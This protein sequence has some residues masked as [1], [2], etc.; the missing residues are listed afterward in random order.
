MPTLHNDASLGIVTSRDASSLRPGEMVSA[1]GCEYHVGSPHLYKLPGRTS[2]DTALGAAVDAVVKLQYESG[3]IL[4]AVCGGSVYESTL[5][6]SPTFGAATLTG[7]T[8]G[9]TPQFTGIQEKWLMWNG[10][11]DNYLR[12]SD[13]TWR[14]VGMQPPLAAP[15]AAVI[16]GS[17][18]SHYPTAVSGSYGNPS[19]A[20]DAVGDTSSIGMV[21][22]TTSTRTQTWKF[23][24]N[25]ATTNRYLKIFHKA[26][27]S[28]GATHGPAKGE[29]TTTDSSNAIVTI[30]YSTD[31][32]VNYT[33]L[34][35]QGVS[36][37]LTTISVLLNDALVMTNN[38]YVKASI[39]GTVGFASHFMYTIKVSAGRSATTPVTNDLYYGFTEVYID[40]DGIVHEGNM[41]ESTI[42]KVDAATANNT[43][44]ITLTFPAKATPHATKYYIYRSIMEAGGGY[45]NMYLIDQVAAGAGNWIDDFDPL[46]PLDEAASDTIY[47]TLDVLYPTGETLSWSAHGPPP[48]AKA[49]VYFNGSALYLPADPSLGSRVYYSLPSTIASAGLEQIPDPYY[50]QFQTPRNDLGTALAVT[51]GG[52]SALVFFENYTMIVNY[53]PQSTDPGGFDNRVVEYVS[54]I[55][56]CAG[57]RATMEFTLPAGQTLVAAVDSLGLWVTNGVNMVQEWSKDLDWVTAFNG[58]DLTTVTLVDK[59]HK[60]RLELLFVGTDGTHQEYHFFY[61]RMKQ[62]GDGGPAPLITGPHP[63]GCSCKHYCTID[64]VWQGFGGDAST[65]GDVFLEDS[66]WADASNGYDTEGNI[67]WVWESPDVYLQGFSVAQILEQINPKFTDHGEPKA[68]TILLSFHRDKGKSYSKTKTYTAG[69]QQQVYVHAYADRHSV[70]FSDI[71]T[72]ESPAFIGYDVEMRGGGPT[73]DK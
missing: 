1:T 12:E 71:S 5:S 16:S 6:T 69:E 43:Y 67:P 46:I 66:G 62:D 30:S 58:V 50:L 22:E 34:L 51:N 59:P 28:A 8:S 29:Q 39:S 73:R 56:G 18:A 41:L 17:T 42:V 35:R 48:K 9:A 31:G 26:T 33:Q 65:T 7:L 32:G 37:G 70:Q 55:R 68:F 24:T 40:D 38:L 64:G 11:D 49:I 25:L 3:D 53:L 60:R 2:T 57:P 15:T 54:N 45:P 47:P 10:T 72:T 23:T 44:G 20:C 63:S 13:G 14:R 19:L 27:G 4:T 61:G 52:K 21:D 36:I